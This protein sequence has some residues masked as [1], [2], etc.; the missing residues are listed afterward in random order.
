[1]IAAIINIVG[2]GLQTGSVHIG[3]FIVARFIT[4]F[5][6]GKLSD[7]KRSPQTDILSYVC[8]TGAYLHCRGCS[9]SY[10]RTARWPAWYVLS[11][12]PNWHF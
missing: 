4:G 8:H 10:T 1:M 12:L 7:V 6:A 2:G 9:S 5:S 3:M 11:L